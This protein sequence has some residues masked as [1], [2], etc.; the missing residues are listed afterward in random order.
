M[1]ELRKTTGE[2]RSALKAAVRRVLTLSGGGDSV[3]YAT[4]VKAPALSRYG[5]THDEHADNHCPIDVA[6]DLDL[7][8]GQPVILAAMAKAQGYE[9]RP[10]AAALHSDLPIAKKI[11]EGMRSSTEFFCTASEMAADG[12]DAVEAAALLALMDRDDEYK[13]R[14]RARLNAILS[15]DHVANVTRMVGGARS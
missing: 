9:L 14:M 5:S 12:L 11:S 13:L 1:S 8:A 3:Q 15:D 4:R 10:T 6:M 7:E 2:L